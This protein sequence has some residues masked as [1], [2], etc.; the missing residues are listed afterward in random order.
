MLSSPLSVLR[1]ALA[2]HV[3]EKAVVANDSGACGSWYVARSDGRS[4]GD[5]RVVGWDVQGVDV[6]LLVEGV[7]VVPW[8]CWLGRGVGDV[9]LGVGSGHRW[10]CDCW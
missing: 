3:A 2:P 4:E 9:D 1:N 7:G 6:G 10:R 8:E 5:E